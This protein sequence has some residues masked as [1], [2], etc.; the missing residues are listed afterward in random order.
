M[1]VLNLVYTKVS[2]DETPWGKTGFHTIF[3]PT[4]LMTKDDIFELEQRI[5]FPGTEK[6]GNKETVFYQN[7]KGE[8]HLV[9]L[10]IRSLPDAK[11]TFGRGGVYLCHGFIFSPDLWKRVPDP[12]ALFELTK[13]NLFTTREQV[14]SCPSVDKKTGD[15]QPLELAEEKISGLA[16]KLPVLTTDFEWRVA[17]L[18]NR[19]ANM[20]DQSPVVI[21]KGEPEKIA[22]LLNRAIAYV[23]DDLKTSLGW[24]PG[25]ENGNMALFPLNIVGFKS[26]RPLG[27]SADNLVEISLETNVINEPAENAKFLVPETLFENWLNHCSEEADSK[28]QVEKAYNLSLMIEKDKPFGLDEILDKR[29]GFASANQARIKEIFL[30]KCRKIVGKT[31]AKHVGGAL[32][33][34]SML[35][36]LIENIPLEE[37]APEVK[38]FSKVD[39]IMFDGILRQQKE[40][41]FFRQQIS[42]MEILENMLRQKLPEKSEMKKLISWARKRKPPG[43]NCP[44]IMSFL[45]PKEGIAPAMLEDKNIKEK[46]IECFI[47][48]HDYKIKDFEPFGFD[49]GVMK[50]IEAMLKANTLKNRVKGLLKKIR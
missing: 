39:T 23:P 40:L 2:P 20:A 19:V 9:I 45:Y 3:Y 42:L 13:Q 32:G 16:E 15:M 33:P 12:L 24:D 10:H 1:D 50:K 41:D 5:H 21:L 44:Y 17:M 28:H 26:D 7:I 25:Y 38:E 48:C 36:L 8:Y 18:M 11:D 14:L 34:E 27:G 43:G 46:L 47:H 30:E 49:E 4:V 29:A 37:L 35:D 31:F 22:E 6:L